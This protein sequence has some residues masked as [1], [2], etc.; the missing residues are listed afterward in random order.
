MRNKILY[1]SVLLFLSLCAYSCKEE[2][3]VD[4][5]YEPAQPRIGEQ[6][7]FT[8]LSGGEVYNWTFGN[9]AISLAKN[10]KRTYTTPGIYK[11]TLRVDSNNKYVR[12][13]EITV[14]DSVP[15]ITRNIE[16]V[17][18]FQNVTFSTLA[19]NPF[20][21]ELKYKWYFSKNAGGESLQDTG[22]EYLISNEASPVVFFKTKDITETVRLEMS[23]GDSIYTTK[24]ISAMSFQV[25][26]APS[27]SL[28]ITRKGKNMIRQRIF[29]NGVESPVETNI[30]SGIYP[31][32]MFSYG[33]QLYI[34]DAGSN[35]GENTNWASDVSGNGNIRAVNL[36][37]NAVTEVINNNG[38]SSYFGF[39]NGFAD[40]KKIYWTDRNNYLYSLDK[41]SRNL[42][43]EWLDASQYTLP[44]YLTQTDSLGIE[45]DVYNGGI[46]VYDNIYFWAKG[47]PAKGIYRFTEK[48]I[49]N[50][51]LSREP[52]L[53]TYAVRAFTIDRINAQI[54]F[55]STDP[56][57]LWVSNMDGTNVRLIEE[58]PLDNDLEYITGIAVDNKSGYLY[59][60][61]RAPEEK[62]AE[63]PSGVKR[64]ALVSGSAKPNLSTLEY[65]NRT[66]SI[67]GIAIDYVEK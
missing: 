18:Y 66:D 29:T 19:Y 26:D 4:F 50:Q 5:E 12:S 64:I 11:V 2:I 65:V 6:I 56:L 46:Y 9:G 22:E 39:Y 17:S 48:D 36:N 54:Y 61:Y 1:F 51:T 15:T 34:F 24:D 47:A 49:A 21:R 63:N 62:K 41:S 55:S 59:W 45:N 25:K 8:N 57:G 14:Y 40:S 38:K 31:F 52:I 28:L 23:I 13:K 32:N 16:E 35:I 58:A 10:P 7:S 33:D 67:Y 37:N 3:Y 20:S 53:D 43:F 27:H 42:S 44:Y 60:A 30:P